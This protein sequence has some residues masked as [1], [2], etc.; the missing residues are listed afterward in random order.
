VKTS[1]VMLA[2]LLLGALLA[3][4][5]GGAAYVQGQLAPVDPTRTNQPF[6]IARGTG[7]AQV[8]QELEA[9]GLIRSARLFVLVAR[10]RDQA[11][12]LHAGEY[13]LSPALGADE[14]LDRLVA[15]RVRHYEVVIPEG[16][17]ATQIASRVEAAGLVSAQDFLAAVS[18]PELAQALGVPADRLE[19]YL[20]PETYRIPRGVD[21]TTIARSMVEQFQRVWAELA[22][23]AAEADLDLHS[24]VTLASIVE[25]ETGAAEERPLIASVFLNRLER[26]MRLETDPTVIF[27]I[28]DFD[29]NLRRVHLEDASNPYNTYRIRGL[30]PG[31][32]ASPGREALEAVLDPATSDYLFFVARGDGTHEFSVRYA[33]HNRAVDRYQRKRRR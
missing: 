8:A 28:P 11:G 31:P 24:I 4:G 20:F 21:A 14:V 13:L 16:L 6:T 15:G 32:I 18:D 10:Y 29:G 25:K 30:P 17:R 23:R 3:G 27:G 22:P 33:D 26:K 19:G 2:A 7:L 9:Q 12:S 1:H 5:A